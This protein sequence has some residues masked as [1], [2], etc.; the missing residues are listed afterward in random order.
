M[1]QLEQ[2]NIYQS[3][4]GEF[5]T[6]AISMNVASMRR[7]AGF[8]PVK[9]VVDQFAIDLVEGRVISCPHLRSPR[10][11]FVGMAL[12]HHMYCRP[13]A[14]TSFFPPWSGDCDARGCDACGQSAAVLHE[15]T[16]NIGPAILFGNICFDCN[17][18]SL[19]EWAS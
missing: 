6:E 3:G 19:S 8:G 16:V 17:K 11:V 4:N 13:C 10:T 1:G 2:G 5:V 15:T 12:P 18:S 9:N 14:E 7:W